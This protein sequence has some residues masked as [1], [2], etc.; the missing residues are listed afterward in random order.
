[1]HTNEFLQTEA[2]FHWI[3]G[4]SSSF[5]HSSVIHSSSPTAASCSSI[6]PTTVSC[7]CSIQLATP[8]LLSMHKVV[9]CQHLTFTRIFSSQLFHLARQL[10]F[11][12]SLPLVY[13]ILA[14]SS[15]TD[16]ST[17]PGYLRQDRH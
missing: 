14:N 7:S 11:P 17:C 9:Q 2:E 6:F 4:S 15:V 16:L 8:T 1:M 5:I 10:L 3:S 13:S 12:L